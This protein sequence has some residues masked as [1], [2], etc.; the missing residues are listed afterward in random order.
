LSDQEKIL[1]AALEIFDNNSVHDDKSLTRSLPVIEYTCD[2]AGETSEGERR[3]S[4]YKVIGSKDREYLCLRQYCSCR[5]YSQMA[6][7]EGRKVLCKHL[8]A[9]K[10]ARAMNLLDRRIVSDD[11][12]S[13][14]L[15][16]AISNPGYYR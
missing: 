10:I 14:A 16:R 1:D 8:L 11:E 3:R 4:F 7:N 15:N 9:V 12:Y 13:L 6:R 5:S 2:L